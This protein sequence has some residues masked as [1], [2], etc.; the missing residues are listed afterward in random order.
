[1]T[2]IGFW[3]QLLLFQASNIELAPCNN[4]AL[5]CSVIVWLSTLQIAVC[6]YVQ[7]VKPI[8]QSV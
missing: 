5:D 4:C 6:S 3:T 2:L 8:K 7:I 1:M